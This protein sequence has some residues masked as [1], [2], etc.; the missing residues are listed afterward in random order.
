MTQHT[1][2]NYFKCDMCAEDFRHH[3]KLRLHKRAE[4]AGGKTTKQATGHGL[5]DVDKLIASGGTE[6]DDATPLES[7]D[8]NWTLELSCEC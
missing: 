8:I 3:Y 4:H 7:N 2:V 5:D 1:N 6:P